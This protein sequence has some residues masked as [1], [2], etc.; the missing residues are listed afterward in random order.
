MK[1]A[2]LSAKTRHTAAN[3][4]DAARM[5]SSSAMQ[6]SSKENTMHQPKFFM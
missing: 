5:V 4:T 3:Y 2:L 1:E 6:N